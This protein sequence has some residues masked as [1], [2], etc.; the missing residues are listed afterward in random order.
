MTTSGGG[1][2]LSDNAEWIEQA[3]YLATQAREPVLHYEH[4]VI[5][6]NY[7]MSNVLA[8]LGLSQLED[9]ERR[10]IAVRK[11]HF[12]AYKAALNDLPGVDLMP[13]SGEGRPT[14]G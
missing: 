8:G 9:L 2:L 5:G 14:T 1:M 3:R 11:A 4:K 10:R 12:E 13:L 7:R 6:F